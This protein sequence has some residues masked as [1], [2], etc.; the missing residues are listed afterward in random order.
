MS[1][2]G[3]PGSNSSH[4]HIESWNNG[5]FISIYT[6][7]EGGGGWVSPSQQQARSVVHCLQTLKA[8]APVSHGHN[9]LQEG[10][11]VQPYHE[12]KRRTRNTQTPALITTTSCSEHRIKLLSD[13]LLKLDVAGCVTQF[14]Q[15]NRGN[16][17]NQEPLR[18]KNQNKI[19]LALAFSLP[20]PGNIP[21]SGFSFSPGSRVRTDSRAPIDFQQAC[22]VSHSCKSLRFE[23][24]LQLEHN[25]V[26][27][28]CYGG[29]RKFLCDLK[30]TDR[31]MMIVMM[32]IMNSHFIDLK[33]ETQKS[34]RIF[35]KLHL[36]RQN[37]NS[38]NLTS[39]D[40]VG[41]A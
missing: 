20:W 16:F 8:S 28:D 39:E 41:R 40:Q 25:P 19:C 31:F 35:P 12:P 32:M 27:L 21:H 18:T 14:S 17:E 4:S 15:R 26:H 29:D 33:T 37:S 2:A 7:Q 1:R 23:E 34:L 11:E 3:W 30:I 5:D 13:L 9:Q 10:R 6:S 24:Y 22:G 36:I 38:G